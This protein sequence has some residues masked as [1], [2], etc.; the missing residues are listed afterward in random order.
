[1]SDV[2][3]A[4]PNEEYIPNEKVIEFIDKFFDTTD[5]NKEDE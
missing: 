3:Q 4:I 2:E 1:M 5:Y